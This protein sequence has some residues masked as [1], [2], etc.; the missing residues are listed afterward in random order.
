MNGNITTILNGVI[1]SGG[2]QNRF[3]QTNAN[4]SVN[5]FLFDVSFVMPSGYTGKWDF[6][7]DIY[8]NI[9]K[10]IGM[11]NGG[12]VALLSNV[13]LYDAMSYSDCEAGVSMS[14]TDFTAGNTCR[15]SGY[16]DT[17]YFGMT[18]RTHWK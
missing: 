7:K 14:G 17:G 15:I 18:S 5:G 10:R 4:L 16:L 11:G 2:T 6:L 8:V 3:T 13:S 1:T 12:A 9:T